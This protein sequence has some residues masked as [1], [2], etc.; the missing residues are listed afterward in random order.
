MGTRHQRRPGRPRPR[1]LPPR[2]Q[3]HVH[4]VDRPQSQRKTPPHRR[5]HPKLTYTN[6]R[7]ARSRIGSAVRTIRIAA[8]SLVLIGSS[9]HDDLTV[10][11]IATQTPISSFGSVNCCG[12]SV[13]RSYFKTYAPVCR[14]I[15]HEHMHDFLHFHPVPRRRRIASSSL[16]NGRLRISGSDD[17]D[18]TPTW[19]P[20]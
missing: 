12:F 3:R 10:K 4:A 9:E 5:R 14:S 18:V 11:N 13:L 19:P 7:R 2:R 8:S 15:S 16:N 17:A 1:R 20:M 6:P